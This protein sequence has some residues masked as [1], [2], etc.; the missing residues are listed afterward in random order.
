MQEQQKSNLKSTLDNFSL[1]LSIISTL[2]AIL[3]IAL[4]I[5]KETIGGKKP[6]ISAVVFNGPNKS[7][8]S[9]AVANAGNAPAIITGVRVTYPINGNTITNRLTGDQLT[10]IIEP[11]KFYQ[12]DAHTLD[13][14]AL[15]LQAIEGTEVTIGN[16]LKSN[17]K[18]ELIYENIQGHEHRTET[19]YKCLTE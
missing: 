19:P 16:P 6:E 11:N 14:E 7:S 13:Q 10:K 2:I 1:I 12:F 18:L 15:P 17:C 8:I 5:I 3:A 4:P 9:Y